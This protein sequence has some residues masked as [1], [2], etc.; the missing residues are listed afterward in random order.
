MAVPDPQ[1][2]KQGQE[3]NPY[4]HGSQSVSLATEPRWELHCLFLLT[5][6]LIDLLWPWV[7]ITRPY[8]TARCWCGSVSTSFAI[9]LGWFSWALLTSVISWENCTFP[10][11]VVGSQEIMCPG[12]GIWVSDKYYYLFSYL[13]S[14]FCLP[15]ILCLLDKLFFASNLSSNVAFS[16]RLSLTTVS[17]TPSCYSQHLSLP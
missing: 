8:T 1:P 13:R 4:P 6:W 15:P 7:S 11:S 5:G 16:R 3:L 2:T 9:C 12:L 14:C 17:E 10:C